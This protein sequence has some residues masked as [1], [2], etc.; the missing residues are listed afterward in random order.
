MSAYETKRIGR[1]RDRR[2]G[3]PLCS[4][5]AP[6]LFNMYKNDQPTKLNTKHFLYANDLAILS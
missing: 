4:V 3:I 6:T 2:S 1:L 5:L